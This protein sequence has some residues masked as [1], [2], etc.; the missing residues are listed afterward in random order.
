MSEQYYVVCRTYIGPDQTEYTDKTRYYV[1]NARPTYP[2]S[3]WGPVVV[4]SGYTHC[5]YATTL[6][7]IWE[8]LEAARDQAKELA[9]QE[10]DY[11][12]G[13]REI[14]SNTLDW[15]L[16]QYRPGAL[17]PMSPEGTRQWANA[18]RP[19]WRLN[20]DDDA[21]LVAVAAVGQAQANEGILLDIA[22]LVGCIAEFI[23]DIR[24]TSSNR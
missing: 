18:A 20:A 14:E 7:G 3:P 10:V 22:T 9:S 4:G 24:S 11:N 13:Y 6:C 1:T 16:Y 2:H 17:Q 19:F 21:E 5:N 23:D 12:P 15:W 8:T